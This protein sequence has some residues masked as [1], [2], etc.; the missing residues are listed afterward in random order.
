MKLTMKKNSSN[1]IRRVWN[2]DKTKLLGVVGTVEDLL[3]DGWLSGYED[4]HSLWCFL[5]IPRSNN[6]DSFGPTRESVLADVKE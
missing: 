4:I 6:K 3:A 5:A 1:S 2:D